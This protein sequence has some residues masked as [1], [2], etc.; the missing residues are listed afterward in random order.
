MVYPPGFA[1]ACDA[2]YIKEERSPG[3]EMSTSSKDVV[4][5]TYGTKAK[6]VL[7]SRKA[8][9]QMQT[10]SLSRKGTSCS[11]LY[12]NKHTYAA[13]GTSEKL[14]VNAHQYQL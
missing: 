1:F 7:N 9:Q 4:S 6:A 3:S 11:L 13:N 8:L 12:S 10:Q 14:L 5:V 2:L